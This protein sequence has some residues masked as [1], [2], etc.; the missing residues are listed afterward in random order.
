MNEKLNRIFSLFAQYYNGKVNIAGLIQ[1]IELHFIDFDSMEE[2]NIYHE[3]RNLDADIEIVR[4]TVPEDK[5]VEKVKMYVEAF[6]SR[7]L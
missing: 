6:K 4:F 1:N 7:V 5:Q 3:L 2:K